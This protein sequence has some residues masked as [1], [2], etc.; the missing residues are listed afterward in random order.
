MRWFRIREAKDIP[1]H[2]R[3]NFE[4]FGPPVIGSTL[5]SGFHAAAPELHPIYDNP[6]TR[7]HAADWLTEQYDRAE[8]KETW[9]ITMEVA[10]TV[11]VLAELVFSALGFLLRKG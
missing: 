6:E 9:S 10:I 5:A 2:E 1:K 8:R 4:R 11:F 3:D 7:R